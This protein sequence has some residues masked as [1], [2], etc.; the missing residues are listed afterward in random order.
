M[1]IPCLLLTPEI[2]KRLACMAPYRLSGA[3]GISPAASVDHAKAFILFGVGNLPFTTAN[4][5]RSLDENK[6]RDIPST[7]WESRAIPSDSN[8]K[9]R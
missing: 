5:V 7:K 1:T 9:C 4:T 6:R 3:L 8:F 2:L